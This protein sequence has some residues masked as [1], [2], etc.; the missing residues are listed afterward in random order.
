[1]LLTMTAIATPIPQVPLADGVRVPALGMG[2]WRMGENKRHRARE[3]AALRAGW[4][5]GM[6]LVDTAEMYADGGAEEVVAQALAE[7]RDGTFVVSKVYP[8]NAGAKSAVAACERSLR[9]LRTDRLDLY[10][11]HWRGRI[12]L[13]ETVDAFERLRKDGKILR[14]GVS[15]FDTGD[16]EEL[17]ALPEGSRCAVNQVLY[18]LGQRG[19]EWSLVRLCRRHAIAVMAYSPFDEGRLLGNADLSRIARSLD[20]TPAQLA[21]AWLLHHEDVIAI[22]KASSAAHVDD[23]RAACAI[24]LDDTTLEKLD[25]A[26]PPPRHSTRLAV[27]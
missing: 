4:D 19:I 15:N 24:R 23:N 11:L 22:P 25:A 10:L 14:W 27:I 26:F 1:M 13:A 17:L 18:H 12:P 2:T 16:L 9:R 7:R 5:A 20:V 21:L 8:H 6:T 3:I